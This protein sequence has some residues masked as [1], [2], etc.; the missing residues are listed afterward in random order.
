MEGLT[1]G[2]DKSPSEAT[3]V[4]KPAKAKESEASTSSSVMASPMSTGTEMSSSDAST[5]SRGHPTSNSSPVKS[6]SVAAGAIQKTSSVHH[7]GYLKIDSFQLVEWQSNVEF[8]S[9]F[10]N[11]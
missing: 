1:N 5:V 3:V 8:L 7:Q 11:G 4:P 10:H 6:A 9:H 2:V